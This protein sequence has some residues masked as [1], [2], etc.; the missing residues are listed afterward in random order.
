MPVR[1]LMRAIAAAPEVPA[2][3]REVSEGLMYR[4]FITVGLLARSWQ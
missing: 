4:D 2:D 1:D 3:V